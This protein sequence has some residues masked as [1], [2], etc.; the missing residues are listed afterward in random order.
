MILG[1]VLNCYLKL[2]KN[3]NQKNLQQLAIEAFKLKMGL[4]PVVMKEIFQYTEN[5]VYEL[6]SGNHPR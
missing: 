2:K 1:L 6:R 5:Q 4:S 3:Y